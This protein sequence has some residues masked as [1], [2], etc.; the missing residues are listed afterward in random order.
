VND[1]ACV[2]I[3]DP[4]TAPASAT[5]A[6]R[7]TLVP[8]PNFNALP[9]STCPVTGQ[10]LFPITSVKI[11][12]NTI[13][14]VANL[15]ASTT[16]PAATTMMLR[17]GED[18][19]GERRYRFNR[20]VDGQNSGIGRCGP[21]APPAA[22]RNALRPRD[23]RFRARLAG[24]GPDLGKSQFGWKTNVRSSMLSRGRASAGVVGSL[25]EVCAIKRARPSVFV[26]QHLSSSAS[27]RFISGT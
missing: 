21:G 16:T 18:R 1:R 13:K 6:K 27:S 22:E 12:Y 24:A 17:A 9:D 2:G 8:L 5:T 26:S 11:T 15:A 4:R 20:F 10:S 19:G 3:S 14:F 23:S 25:N 7:R